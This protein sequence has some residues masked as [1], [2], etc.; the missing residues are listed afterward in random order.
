LSDSCSSGI[1]LISP[2][3]E[4]PKSSL[5][6]SEFSDY[7]GIP[8]ICINWIFRSNFELTASRRE[9]SL[10]SELKN[11]NRNSLFGVGTVAVVC[12]VIWQAF[13][14]WPHFF[15]SSPLHVVKAGGYLFRSGEIWHDIGV[16]LLEVATGLALGGSMAL[17]VLGGLSTFN[18]LRGLFSRLLPLTYISAIVVWLLMWVFPAVVAVLTPNWV[19]L[20]HKVVVVGFLT[21][22]PFMQGLWGL[23]NHPLSYRILLAIDDALPIAF[24]A[25]M[26]GELWASTAGLGFMMTVASATY[27]TDKGLVGFIIIVILLTAFSA[28][29][30]SIAK[31]LRLPEPSAEVIPLQAG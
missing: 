28:I 1:W 12:L 24:V 29:L 13:A 11:A 26:F 15:S 25:M 16:S 3:L 2:E 8:N 10:T 21:F 23:R 4:I 14:Q 19:G 17:I 6:H 18:P 20:W 31:R 27:Q 5:I 7:L 22:F 30:R 9:I